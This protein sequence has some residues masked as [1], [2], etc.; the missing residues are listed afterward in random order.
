MVHSASGNGIRKAIEVD[1]AF[2]GNNCREGEE[3]VDL[4]V[5]RR[6]GQRRSVRPVL[7][8]GRVQRQSWQ[9]SFDAPT[10]QPV[11]SFERRVEGLT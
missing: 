10:A 8:R 9:S 7:E 1:E 11:F 3:D 2:S 6:N 5:Y 4:L